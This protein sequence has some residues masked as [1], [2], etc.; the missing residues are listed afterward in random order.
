MENNSRQVREYGDSEWWYKDK[1]KI[2][3]QV[4]QSFQKEKSQG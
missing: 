1:E 4:L 3:K 2:R